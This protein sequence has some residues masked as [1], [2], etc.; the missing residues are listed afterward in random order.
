MLAGGEGGPNWHPID[1]LILQAALGRHPLTRRELRDILEHVARAGFNLQ[2]TET[3]HSD[4][5]G[6]VWQGHLLTATDRIRPDHRHFLKHVVV[7]QEWPLDTGLEEYVDSIS[8]VVLD[9]TAGVC[10][11]QYLGAWSLAIVRESR[12][13][14]GPGGHDWVL[15]QYRL[16]WRHWVTAFQPAKG[17]DELLEP[18]WG[19]V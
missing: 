8:D 5:A 4:L 7:D 1:S 16:G 18:Q 3:A 11:N 15:V 10:T 6:I 2:A 9:P 17:L 19:D 13:L 12:E 14:R